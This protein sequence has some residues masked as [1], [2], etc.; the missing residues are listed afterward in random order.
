MKTLLLIGGGHAHLHCLEQ[1]KNDSLDDL[2]VMLISPSRHQYYSGMFS[3]F[4]EGVYNIE[5]IRIDLEQLCQKAGA[6]FIEDAIMSI[7]AWSQKVMSINGEIYP[8]DAISFDIGSRIEIPAEFKPYASTIKPNF[9]FPQ[10]L[11]TLRDSPNPVIVGGGA[12]GVELAFS[13]LAWRKQNGFPLNVALFSSNSLLS[14]HDAAVS[15]KIQITAERKAL[16]FFVHES[17][18]KID[19]HSVTTSH[20]RSFPQTNVLWLTGPKSPRFFRTSG[21]PTDTQGFLLVNGALQ[22]REFPN[23][24]GAGDCISVDL[25][26]D[27]AKNGVY[28]VRQGPILW[29]NLKNYLYGNPLLL[30]SPQKQYMSILSTGNGEA[31]L[32]Y[33]KYTA[34]GKLPWILKQRIDRK[35]MEQYKKLYEE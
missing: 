14:D 34:H 30:F 2:R 20:D 21:L 35:F 6:A 17:V 3:G 33:G 7:D 22:C 13:V 25:Y 23:V 19:S 5:D 4:T 29:S 28:A 18:E 9:Q 15:K 32:T 12:S 16:P 24:F 11:S 8:Y 1:L 27:L 10:T 31:F 26:P